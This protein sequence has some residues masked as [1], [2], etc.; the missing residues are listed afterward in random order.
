MDSNTHSI[1]RSTRRPPGTPDG[2]PSQPPDGLTTLAAAVDQ[3]AAQHRARLPAATRADRLLVFG[4]LTDRLEGL[5]PQELA[6]VDAQGAAGAERGVPAPSTA[7]WLRARL[8]MGAGAAHR[9]V[10][11]A[12]A[13]FR[14]PLHRTGQ[15]VLAGELA[16]AHA[17][18]LAD[19]TQDLS[20]ATVA[21]AE[22]VLVDAARRLDPPRLRRAVDQLRWVADP[23]TAEARIQRRHGRRG[24]GCRPPWRG[25]WRWMGCWSPRPATRSWRRWRR[26]P[27]R[28]TPR[29]TAAAPSAARMG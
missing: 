4:G 12:R 18:V 27:A 3:L 5:W 8:R 14:G 17:R 13:L 26:W 7:S 9:L 21:E 2:P 6:A 28:P 20:A 16:P 19:R 1:G 11:T 25:W 15:A 10:R 22:P 23:D 24:C 29:T